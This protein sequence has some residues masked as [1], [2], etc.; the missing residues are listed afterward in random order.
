M[1]KPIWL[2]KKIN[3]LNNRKMDMLLQKLKLNTVCK[4][5]RCPNISECFLKGVATFMIMGNICTRN[6]KFCNIKKGKPSSLDWDEPERIKEA[7]EKL[8]LK[9]IVMTSPTRDDLEDGGANFYAYTISLL[10]RI[11]YL[12]I[13]VLIPDFLL[14]KQSL[15]ILVKA[16]PDVI[17]HNIETVPSL[18]KNL[19]PKSDYKR[20][21]G[22]LK[23]L[24]EINPRIIT[25]SGIMLGLGEKEKEVIEV[26]KDLRGV[27]CDFLSIGQ[28]L[29]PSLSHAVLKEY[30]PIDKF[31]RLKKVALL[32][33]FKS[34]MSA[35]YVR[36]SYLA[37]QY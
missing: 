16:N 4:E 12:K 15:E 30:V 8:K 27:H 6:C 35:P 29:P 2:N 1:K 5:A 20:S 9:Y 18:Y 21:L 37:D 31:L 19:R 10:K 28:Y 26:L 25:K 32:L 23:L 34:V 13:E 7:V 11:P 24:K 36:S 14:R 3:F 22:V 33:G 17:A